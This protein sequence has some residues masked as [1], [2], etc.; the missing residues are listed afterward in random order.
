[1]RHSAAPTTLR[2]SQ[3]RAGGGEHRPW[4]LHDRSSR[5]P[6][7]EL[8]NGERPAFGHTGRARRGLVGP[9]VDPGNITFSHQSLS[10]LGSGHTTSGSGSESLPD[11]SW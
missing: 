3:D 8:S 11:C 4:A 1:M 2:P 5:D 6:T 9:G 10:G 7:N